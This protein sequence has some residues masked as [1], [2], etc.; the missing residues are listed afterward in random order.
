MILFIHNPQR[1]KMNAN[2]TIRARNT[3]N[4]LAETF[5]DGVAQ[6]ILVLTYNISLRELKE[7]EWFH[8]PRA[9]VAENTF[10]EKLSQFGGENHQCLHHTEISG[11]LK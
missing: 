1:S 4:V 2:N 11:W 6:E 7:G 8:S 10:R 3:F 5:D 9:T